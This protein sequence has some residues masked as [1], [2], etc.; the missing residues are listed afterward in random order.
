MDLVRGEP[1]EG[2][3][4]PGDAVHC[5][6]PDGGGY[7]Q[8]RFRE[9]FQIKRLVSPKRYTPAIL[10][11]HTLATRLSR[12]PTEEIRGVGLTLDGQTVKFSEIPRRQAVRLARIRRPWSTGNC[13][14][15]PGGTELGWANLDGRGPF[16]NSSAEPSNGRRSGRAQ[17]LD[18]V[19]RVGRDPAIVNGK[20][21]TV[22]LDS[23]WETRRRYFRKATSHAWAV[24]RR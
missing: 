24:L 7:R 2:S 14:F 11:I 19:L 20:P 18:W 4:S 16:F 5:R 13:L 22:R 1:T 15:R 12:Y 17:V 10:R 8:S 23:I 3:P 9:F 21:L 6:S